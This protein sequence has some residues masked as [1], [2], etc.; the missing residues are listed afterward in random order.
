MLLMLGVLAQQCFCAL[1]FLASTRFDVTNFLPQMMHTIRKRS[2]LLYFNTAR[3]QVTRYRRAISSGLLS[4]NVLSWGV[5]LFFWATFTNKSRMGV[6]I[7]LKVRPRAGD[8]KVYS[9]LFS[10]GPKKSVSRGST[11]RSSRLNSLIDLH[12]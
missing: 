5:S 3:P 1:I 7:N 10:R 4:R 11:R 2:E 8:K 6:K 9:P 12:M